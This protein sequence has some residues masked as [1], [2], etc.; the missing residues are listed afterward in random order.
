MVDLP[1]SLTENEQIERLAYD[2]YEEEGKPDGRADE[3]WR[4]AEEFVHAQRLAIAAS[5]EKPEA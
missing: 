1:P 3:H 4:R 5:S 2:L